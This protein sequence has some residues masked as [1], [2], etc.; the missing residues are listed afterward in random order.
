MS[1]S[2]ISATWLNVSGKPRPPRRYLISSITDVSVASIS[3]SIRKSK[4]G[5]SVKKK[6]KKDNRH[7]STRNMILDLFLRVH[8]LVH[9]FSLTTF[10]HTHLSITGNGIDTGTSS[11]QVITGVIENAVL[12]WPEIL[13]LTSALVF[14]IV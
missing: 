10:W 5:S 9:K 2:V 8:I 13:I 11:I 4:N 3:N 6:K 12:E 7:M 14:I 1:T